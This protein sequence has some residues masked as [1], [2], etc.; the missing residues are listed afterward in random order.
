MRPAEVTVLPASVDG[1]VQV[2][3]SGVA[4]GRGGFGFEQA[5][6]YTVNADGCIDVRA[7]I[8]P[9]GRRIVLPRLGMRVQLDPSLNHLTYYARGPQENYPDR[10]TGAEIARYTSTVR[11]QFTPY[12]APMECGNHGDARWC[13]VTRGP[14]GPG[15][16]VDFVL[17]DTAGPDG[18]APV[19]GFA[20][21]ALPFTDED[22][23]KAAYPK[24]LLASTSTVLCL[25]AKSLGVGSAGCGPAPFA[26]YRIYAE[27]TVFSFRLTP[28]PGGAAAPVA[29]VPVQ[30]E[31]HGRGKTA[32][33]CAS[34]NGDSAGSPKARNRRSLK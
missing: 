18:A 27:P 23:E 1:T 30:Q 3:I 21:S 10:Q 2:Q 16:R 32:A 34:A 17:P 8:L 9:K 25:A 24:D 4:E 28:L 19:G 12:G 11:E 13:A 14:Q 22:L 20:F 29:P 15:L 5:I 7:S 6:N 31:T 26:P 33:R